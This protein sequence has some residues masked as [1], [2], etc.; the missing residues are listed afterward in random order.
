[1]SLE[2]LFQSAGKNMRNFNSKLVTAVLVLWIA[3][4]SILSSLINSKTIPEWVLPLVTPSA[5]VLLSAT[6]FYLYK[7]FLWRAKFFSF[8]A[9]KLLGLETVPNIGGKYNVQIWSTWNDKVCYTGKV[10]ITQNYKDI[11]ISGTFD[12]S[13]FKTFHTAIFLN[14]NCNTAKPKEWSLLYS[15]SSKPYSTS[16]GEESTGFVYHDGIVQLCICESDLSSLQGFYGT[17]ENRKTRGKMVLKK[18]K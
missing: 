8:I 9:D 6:V 12:S 17:D 18:I 13:G 14:E 7:K 15:Y 4:N 16:I 5:I 11:F 1:M 3:V 10:K 2:T